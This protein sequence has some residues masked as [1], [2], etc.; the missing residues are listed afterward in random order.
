MIQWIHPLRS[1]FFQLDSKPLQSPT[2]DIHLPKATCSTNSKAD[3]C[4]SEYSYLS[5]VIMRGLRACYQHQSM[6]VP[7]IQMAITHLTIE[8]PVPEPS[9]SVSD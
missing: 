6:N 4:E 3:R 1:H 5:F 2:I 7:K 8:L 9:S